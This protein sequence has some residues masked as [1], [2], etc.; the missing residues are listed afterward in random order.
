MQAARDAAQAHTCY[1]KKLASFALQRDIVAQDMP[2]LTTLTTTSMAASGSVK[3]LIVELVRN[4]AF[5]TRVG[6]TP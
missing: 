3:Q 4:N 5:R 1:A 2:M 6:G